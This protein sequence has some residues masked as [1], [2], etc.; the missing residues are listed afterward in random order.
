MKTRRTYRLVLL[1]IT[2]L[3]FSP[4]LS[5]SVAN[6]VMQASPVQQPPVNSISSVCHQNTDNNDCKH[7]QTVSSNQCDHK[8]GDNCN[9][10]C[11]HS[12]VT[13]TNT[14]QNIDVPLSYQDNHSTYLQAVISIIIDTD[15]RP[16]QSI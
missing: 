16:P 8:P 6:A 2:T 5:V 3:V 7:C 1:I 4:L 15:L 14:N 9:N 12:A 13:A 10:N 11:G